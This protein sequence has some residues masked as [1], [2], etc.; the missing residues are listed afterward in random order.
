MGTETKL[1]R[2]SMQLA[3][4][5]LTMRKTGTASATV[6]AISRPGG[7]ITVNVTLLQRG[8]PAICARIYR[9]P[10]SNPD[11]LQQWLSLLDQ[12]QGKK[13]QG[14]HARLSRPASNAPKHE[15]Q[16][17]LAETLLLDKSEE[18]TRQAGDADYPGVPDEVDLL[19]FVTTGNFNLAEGRGTGVGSILLEKVLRDGSANATAAAAADKHLCI[20]RESGQ[21][22]GRLA[23]W[24]LV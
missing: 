7:L 12:M 20:V 10:R 22:L 4:S 18:T 5:V 15:H 11:L 21:A 13:Q 23:R 6:A 24:E 9:L 2:L 3:K 16:R 1:H 17:Y 8:V 14:K 19:G